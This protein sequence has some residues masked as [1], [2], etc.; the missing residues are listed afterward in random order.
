MFAAILLFTNTFY[1]MDKKLKIIVLASGSATKLTETI[2]SRGHEYVLAK[3]RDF[4]LFLS[5]SVHGYDSVYLHGEKLVA[6]QYDA[7][8]T[9][10]GE[11]REFGGRVLRQLRN[12]GI[13]CVQ[14]GEAIDT[15]ADKFKSAQI[16]SK[17]H[18]RVPR[19]FL[20]NDPE[21]AKMLTE[22]LGGLPIILKENS[23][24]KGKGLILLE[25]ERQTNMTLESYLGSY[26]RIILQEYLDNGGKDERHIVCGGKVVNSM[27][28]QSPE[29]DIRAN[30][31]LNGTGRAITPDPETERICIDAVAAIPNLNFAGVDI[32]KAK[33]P[34][35]GEIK[36]YFI[37]VN[38][39]PGELIMDITGHN[40]YEDLIDFIENNYKRKQLAASG[41]EKALAELRADLLKTPEYIAFTQTPEYAAFMQLE[42]KEQHPKIFGILK[43]GGKI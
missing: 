6:S 14:S 30:L 34:K 7:C 29:D 11:Q 43:N 37:E 21:S 2:E 22:R 28:R 31:S 33:D 10:L 20:T 13:F 26:R 18:I 38:S 36:P 9:R 42:L 23:G 1:N 5:S 24:S 40:H 8:V 16:M 15:C 35:D 27:E 32:I 17:S 41:D 12:I 25:S 39:N 4:D 3:P 19:Q